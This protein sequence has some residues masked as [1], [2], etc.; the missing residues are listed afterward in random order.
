MRYSSGPA[1]TAAPISSDTAD[2]V[3]REVWCRCT[4]ALNDA[5]A[6]GRLDA[7]AYSECSYEKWL[8]LETY[9]RVFHEWQ[10]IWNVAGVRPDCGWDTWMEIR[11]P[12]EENTRERTDLFV[13]VTEPFLGK[14][15]Y[16]Q[17]RSDTPVFEFKVLRTDDWRDGVASVQRDVNRFSD[18]RLQHCYLIVLFFMRPPEIREQQ[19][20]KFRQQVANIAPLYA[21]GD[22]CPDWGPYCPDLSAHWSDKRFCFFAQVFRTGVV[23][24]SRVQM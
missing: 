21:A 3:A 5:R 15:E 20:G 1:S 6:D 24:N 4:H 13:G 9:S 11:V 7:L 22:Y 10:A 2:L 18:A 16:K 12:D 19:V 14:K 8:V 17:P 23:Q